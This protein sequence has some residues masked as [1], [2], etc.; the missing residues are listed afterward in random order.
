MKRSVRDHALRRRPARRAG[1]RRRG[2]LL[3]EVILAL[4]I[5]FM[6][7]AVSSIRLPARAFFRC[8]SQISNK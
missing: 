5:L 1:D 3:L 6:G 7:M 8:S 2:A 4:A